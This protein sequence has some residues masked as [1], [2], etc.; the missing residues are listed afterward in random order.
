MLEN[1][2]VVK[3]EGKSKACQKWKGE[4]QW[5]Q[6]IWVCCFLQS[7]VRPWCWQFTAASNINR[8]KR[9]FLYCSG[10]LIFLSFIFLIPDPSAQAFPRM[11][12]GE[13]MLFL[14]TFSW[15]RCSIPMLQSKAWNLA[16][17]WPQL[18]GCASHIIFLKIHLIWLIYALG[19]NIPVYSYSVDTLFDTNR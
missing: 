11:R 3:K 15:N 17:D 2:L 18:R 16:R 1:P 12:F 6:I 9:N 13:N 14:A 5:L 19:K 4:I 8:L 7:I 10:W